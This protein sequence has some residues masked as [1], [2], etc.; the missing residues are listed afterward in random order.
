[1]WK[2]NF[3]ASEYILSIFKKTA[4]QPQRNSNATA[5]QQQRIQFICVI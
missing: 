4:T 5:T 3:C 2:F 1:M